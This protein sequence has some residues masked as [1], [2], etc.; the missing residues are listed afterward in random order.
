MSDDPNHEPKV[1]KPETMELSF[2]EIDA[3]IGLV[4]RGMGETKQDGAVRKSFADNVR[5]GRLRAC[6]QNGG[7]VEWWQCREDLKR[8]INEQGASINALPN[9]SEAREAALTKI[10][11]LHQSLREAEALGERGQDDVPHRQQYRVPSDLLSWAAKCVRNVEDAGLLSG[12]L[13]AVVQI[14]DQ[15]G[16]D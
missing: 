11:E 14:A 16:I 1:Q 7:Y 5:L 15:L 9:H 2:A 12:Q 10:Q 6:F 3:L 8:D 4:G 13:D